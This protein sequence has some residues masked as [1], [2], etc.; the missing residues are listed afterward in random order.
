MTK[1]SGLA[2]WTR[3]QHVADLDLLITQDHSINEQLYQLSALGKRQPL[4]AWL[5]APAKALKPL[6]CCHHIHLLL[7][8]R[9]QLAHLLPQSTP[10]L[11]H[12]LTFPFKFLPA[13]NL[14]QIDF[15]QPRLLPVEL[16]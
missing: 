13:N 5:D 10:S 1:R 2:C 11:L 14:R 15:Q 8:L 6:R 16:S 9:L 7:R 4:Q 3:R 12:L